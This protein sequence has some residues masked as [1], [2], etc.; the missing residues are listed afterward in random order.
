MSLIKIGM[1]DGPAVWPLCFLVT[2][3]T[4]VI[5]IMNGRKPKAAATPPAAP[6]ARL[7]HFSRKGIAVGIYAEGSIKELIQ[8]G[9]IQTTD[10]YWSEGMSAWQKVADNPAWR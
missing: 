7:F 3:V 9:H 6:G 2:T 10:D 5:L 4:V 1:L 8:S